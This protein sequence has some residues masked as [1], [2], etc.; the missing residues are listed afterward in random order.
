[1]R[2]ARADVAAFFDGSLRR[3]ADAAGSAFGS[4]VGAAFAALTGAS[5][6][7]TGC[8]AGAG[9]L[10]LATGGAGAAVDA[11]AGASDTVRLVA[12]YA[13]PAAAVMHARASRRNASGLEN[14]NC[15][16]WPSWPSKARTP[17]KPRNFKDLRRSDALAG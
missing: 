13:P 4:G 8:D 10:V 6:S 1:V 15:T 17:R 11:A 14:M 12:T 7:A 3:D 9:V 2:S 5:V 16:P